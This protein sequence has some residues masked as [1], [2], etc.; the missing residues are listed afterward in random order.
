MTASRPPDADA[1]PRCSN[2]SAHSVSERPDTSATADVP[3][4]MRYTL[5]EV[6]DAVL[7]TAKLR[8]KEHAALKAKVKAAKK[9]GRLAAPKYA[10]KPAWLP[11]VPR[12][13]LCCSSLVCRLPWLMASTAEGWEPDYAQAGREA[14]MHPWQSLE[15]LPPVPAGWQ[16]HSKQLQPR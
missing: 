4:W 7:K 10:R 9:E 2:C 16:G 13:K 8:P 14:S 11:A 15:S 5:D 6:S 1:R 3:Q 12:L